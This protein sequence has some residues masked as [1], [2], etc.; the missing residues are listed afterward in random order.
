MLNGSDEIMPNDFE[1]S[2]NKYIKN[3]L[4]IENI[5]KD[6][7]EPKQNQ[8]VGRAARIPIPMTRRYN[9]QYGNGLADIVND[10]EETSILKKLDE[11]FDC[12]ICL[13]EFNPTN[14]NKNITILNKCN[15][16]ICNRCAIII[17]KESDE[18]T[19]PMCRQ[20]HKSNVLNNGLHTDPQI[21]ES[22][23]VSTN[24]TYNEVFNELLKYQD[25][26]IVSN[27]L[28]ELNS[29]IEILNN[30]FNFN[31]KEIDIERT[32]IVAIL[33]ECN[34]INLA[35]QYSTSIKQ[36]MDGTKCSF[37]E[38]KL[39]FDSANNVNFAID[40]LIK[41]QT[42]E[43]SVNKI[44]QKTT[45]SKSKAALLFEQYNDIN[46]IIELFELNEIDEIDEINDEDIHLVM[47]QAHCTAKEAID[48]LK[49]NNYDFVNAIMELTI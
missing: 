26:E 48:A 3:M 14:Y 30:I 7:R 29:N 36:V 45:L 20:V 13:V 18:I 43:K 11:L 24:C 5:Y 6:Y 2:L 17:K 40:T 15:H 46:K 42:K 8:I 23:M 37:N 4:I 33:K 31:D 19:C 1:I 32:A 27:K 47:D 12:P 25:E 49:N 35:I 10:I 39:Y 44:C 16:K 41:K 38:A 28:L 34:N 21:I 22:L 9:A